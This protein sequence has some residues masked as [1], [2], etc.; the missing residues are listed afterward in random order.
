ML[1]VPPLSLPSSVLARLDQPGKLFER[2]AP[3]NFIVL[4][5]EPGR[6]VFVNC[7]HVGSA[8]HRAQREKDEVGAAR[9]AARAQTTGEAEQVCDT[10]SVA[11]LSRHSIDP[12]L[13]LVRPNGPK[14]TLDRV[15]PKVYTGKL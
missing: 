9:R 14:A 10:S 3:P 4:W 12:G 11:D 15:V 13:H 6:Q 8:I 5:S 7:K 1:I 2:H